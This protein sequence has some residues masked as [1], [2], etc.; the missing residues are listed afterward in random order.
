MKFLAIICEFN[1]FHNGH[2]YLIEKAKEASGC[3]AVLCIMSGNFT[4]RGNMCIADKYTRAKHAVSGGADCVIQL[5]AYFAVA[6][7]EIFAKGAIKILSSIPSVKLLAFGCENPH[8]DFLNGAKLLIAENEQFKAVLESKLSEGESYIKSYALAFSA[9]GGD[10]SLISNPNN[11]LGLE[12]AKAILRQNSKIG[13]FP[14][15][16]IGGNYNET[17]LKENYSSASAIRNNLTCEKVK[18]N[19]P[20]FVY[21]DLHNVPDDNAFSD[22]LR[23]KLFLT[24]AE[25]LKKV[26][27]GGEGLENKLKRLEKEPFEEIIK[28]ATSKRY[29]SSR[30]QRMLCANALGLNRDDCDEILNEELYI[31]PLAV[32]KERADEILSALSRSSFQTVTGINADQLCP[33]AKKCFEKDC[34]EFALYKF[35]T[36]CDKKDYMMLI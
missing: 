13:L 10:I 3:D 7:A 11:I 36:R 16:R 6:P 9:C 28:K 17:T 14:V 15:Q 24:K 32:K 29:T 1:P 25:E 12:Y 4:Q 22:F 33:T 2:R 8:G 23:N 26:Y 20:D 31:K 5:P 30:I 21:N 27:G 35:L 18:N 19:L 34:E